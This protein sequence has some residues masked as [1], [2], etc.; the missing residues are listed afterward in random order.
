MELVRAWDEGW[1]IFHAFEGRKYITL[2]DYGTL[3]K[4]RLTPKKY[5]E[6]KPRPI[7]DIPIKRTIKKLKARSDYLHSL[8]VTHSRQVAQQF[9]KRWKDQL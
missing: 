8:D 9:I 2:L 4:Q 6:M 5:R 7:T 1:R 3:K